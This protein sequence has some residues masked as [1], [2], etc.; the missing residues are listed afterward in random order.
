MA[1]DDA[2]SLDHKGSILKVQ[3]NRLRLRSWYAGDVR[4]HQPRGRAHTMTKREGKSRDQW[5][6]TVTVDQRGEISSCIA[7]LQ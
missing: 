4:S 3:Q 5:R 6:K 1:K 2:R 7:E